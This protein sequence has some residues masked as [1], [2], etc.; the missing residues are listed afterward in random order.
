M[1][2]FFI[3]FVFSEKFIQIRE[4]KYITGKKRTAEQGI[5]ATMEKAKT[6]KARVEKQDNTAPAPEKQD[7]KLLKEV[8]RLRAENS[9]YQKHFNALEKEL[10]LIRLQCG[11]GGDNSKQDNLL[12]DEITTM[13]EGIAEIKTMF[14]R[15]TGNGNNQPQ[16]QTVTN[17][18][19]CPS[20]PYYQTP[21]YAPQMPAM[22]SYNINLYG[23]NDKK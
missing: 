22:P 9:A 1:A 15:L 14:E 3:N 19:F 4:K 11:S 5:F 2:C 23:S 10:R 12:A 20:L 7:D 17:P 18:Q 13:R 21:N 6:T 16:S 8:E